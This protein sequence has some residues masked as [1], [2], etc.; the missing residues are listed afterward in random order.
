MTNPE[1]SK[2]ITQFVNKEINQ[3]QAIALLKSQSLGVQSTKDLFEIISENFNSIDKDLGAFIDQFSEAIQETGNLDGPRPSDDNLFSRL[4]LSAAS[5]QCHSSF[6]EG[7]DS[8]DLN[9]LIQV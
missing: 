2:I 3:K 6:F 9:H 7:K 8:F 5:D 4:N 1:V